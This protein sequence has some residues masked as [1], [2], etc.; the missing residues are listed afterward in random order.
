MFQF[1]ES[2]FRSSWQQF[3]THLPR[4][5]CFGAG[6]LTVNDSLLATLSLC[7]CTTADRSQF[8]FCWAGDGYINSDKWANTKLGETL[9]W[10]KKA[11]YFICGVSVTTIWKLFQQKSICP[12]PKLI[13]SLR[14]KYPSGKD[15]IHTCCVLQFQDFAN[16]QRPALIK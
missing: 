10:A 12:K 7:L 6:Y 16:P 5:S 2:Y 13:S 15:F 3:F 4:F 9:L 1:Y 8:V 11:F 14:K